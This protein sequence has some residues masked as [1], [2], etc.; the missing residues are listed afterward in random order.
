MCYVVNTYLANLPIEFEKIL[1]G[2]KDIFS[3]E[4]PHGLLGHQ[5][6][7][8]PK[9]PMTLA[10]DLALVSRDLIPY[11]NGLL[12]KAC[13]KAKKIARGSASKA[14]NAQRLKG[15]KPR[16]KRN[17]ILYMKH[18]NE[19]YKETSSSMATPSCHAITG[20]IDAHIGKSWW[21]WK[22]KTKFPLVFAVFFC[23]DYHGRLGTFINSRIDKTFHRLIRSPRSSEV[24]NSSH[25]SSVFAFDFVVLKSNSGNFDF[26]YDISYSDLANFDFDLGVCISKFS[27]DNMVDNNKTLK[28]LATPNE[29][30][31]S[32]ELT[33]RLIHLLP[34]LHGLPGQDPYKHLKEFHVVCATMRPHGILEDYPSP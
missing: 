33:S 8:T 21:I 1:E 11:A 5:I 16:L 10:K 3:K 30:A 7:F 28:K 32:Y 13:R 29:Q 2:S 31:Q 19:N 15:L 14:K 17:H 9:V 18:E 27:M 26:D 34:K 20:A 23:D 6:Y 12:P 25:K 24:A 4:V 22:A